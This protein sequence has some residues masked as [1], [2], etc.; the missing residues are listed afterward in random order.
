MSHLGDHFRA[1]RMDR[2]L[3]TGELA[4]MVG[5][6]NLSRGSN[7]IQAFESGGKVAPDLLSKLASALEI[8]PD[9][10]RR[11][12]AADYRDWLDWASE[13]IRPHIVLRHMA[14]VYQRLELPD[15]ALAPEA[16]EAFAARLAA[17]KK[18]MVCLVLSRRLSIGFDAT[19][20][21]YQRLEAA[22]DVPCEPYAL[23]GGKRVQFDFD[24]GDVLRSIDEPG[25]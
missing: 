25:R 17:E 3:S 11:L 12:A 4:R 16:A 8:S 15:D 2:K 19:G 6:S 1:R 18:R 22:P 9:E 20:K 7:R 21:E 5:Y 13:P 23:I 14:C 10:V 24:G